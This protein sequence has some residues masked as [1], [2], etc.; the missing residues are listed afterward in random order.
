MT[1][2]GLSLLV[3]QLSRDL[4]NIY[5]SWSLSLVWKPT[6]DFIFSGQLGGARQESEV[7]FKLQPEYT[8][9]WQVGA[10]ASRSLQC[11]G[12]SYQL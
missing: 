4:L 10:K 12:A 2:F 6:I 9:G 8:S 3:N 5:V 11:V 7:S 1:Y